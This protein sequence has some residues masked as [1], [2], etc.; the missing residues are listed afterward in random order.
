MN[1]KDPALIA[2][3]ASVFSVVACQVLVR[4]VTTHSS[5]SSAQ[6]V[7][8]LTICLAGVVVGL[9]LVLG[10]SAFQEAGAGLDPS[11]GAFGLVLG[12]ALLFALLFGHRPALARLAEHASHGSAGASTVLLAPG[13][14]R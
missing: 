9:L 7:S 10:A 4:A 3:V 14:W 13:A 11:L 2:L 5:L 8:G 12:C 6:V 1:S